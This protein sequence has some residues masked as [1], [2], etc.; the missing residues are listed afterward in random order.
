VGRPGLLR[1]S[2]ADQ[3][4]GGEQ[5]TGKSA[6]CMNAGPPRSY[7]VALA[8]GAVSPELAVRQAATCPGWRALTSPH[9]AGA[10]PGPVPRTR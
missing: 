5:L 10:A 4:L 6:E 8:P 2:V 3:T 7:L 9:R 1:V